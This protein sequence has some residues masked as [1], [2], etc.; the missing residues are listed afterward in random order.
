MRFKEAAGAYTGLLTITSVNDY[1]FFVFIFFSLLLFGIP[2]QRRGGVLK[3]L[4]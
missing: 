2:C 4:L 3:M 1:L